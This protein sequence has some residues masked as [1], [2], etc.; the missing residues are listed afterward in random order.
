VQTRRHR[1]L[2][3]GVLLTVDGA[4]CGDQDCPRHALLYKPRFAVLP[5]CSD[6]VLLPDVSC[7]PFSTE[8]ALWEDLLR[9][10]LN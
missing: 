9:L 8:I 4:I 2:L 7:R 3:I 6:V 5:E 10:S 1:F